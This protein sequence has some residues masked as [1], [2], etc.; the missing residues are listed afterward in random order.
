MG[1][2]ARP[3]GL[4]FQLCSLLVVW[5]NKFNL[6]IYQVEQDITSQDHCEDEMGQIV[7]AFRIVAGL[8]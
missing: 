8:Q 1:S 6:F 7:K 4:K 5:L 3:C 2:G